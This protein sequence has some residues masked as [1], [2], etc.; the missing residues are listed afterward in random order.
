[1]NFLKEWRYSRSAELILTWRHRNC[2]H[3]CSPGFP[4]VTKWRP[5]RTWSHDHFSNWATPSFVPHSAKH[6][7][8][9]VLLFYLSF[10]ICLYFMS[11]PPSQR[12]PEHT[13]IWTSMFITH[14][15]EGEYTSWGTLAC[16]SKMVWERTCYKTWIWLGN[17]GSR[18][19]FWIGCYPKSRTILWLDSSG[20]A[21]QLNL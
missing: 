2:I 5:G 8:F 21:A 1:M 14:F 15:S 6:K 3:G 18:D 12:P 11:M 17:L 7:T 9:I 20:R 4:V 16:V 10:Q 13:C 19:S